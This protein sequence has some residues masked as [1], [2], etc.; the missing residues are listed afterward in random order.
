M[1]KDSDFRACLPLDE[2][3]VPLEGISSSLDSSR[4]G[5]PHTFRCVCIIEPSPVR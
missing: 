5:N 3:S 2:V 4:L 1:L